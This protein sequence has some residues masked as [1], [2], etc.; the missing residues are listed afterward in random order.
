MSKDVID[1]GF[2]NSI[3]KD[4]WHY[5]IKNSHE[6][7][8][9]RISRRSSQEEERV[10]N[11]L[12]PTVE[13]AESL[14][15]G[16][17]DLMAERLDKLDQEIAALQKLTGNQNM[18][19]ERVAV[20]DEVKEEENGDDC[21]EEKEGEHEETNLCLMA[22]STTSVSSV[23]FVESESTENRYYQLL[24]AFQEL[25]EGAMKLQ[26]LINKFKSENKRLENRI[27]VLDNEN[28]SLKSKLES[29]ENICQNT[30]HV[31]KKCDQER[32]NFPRQLERIKY[33][34]KTL[35]KFTLGSSNHDALLG[36]QRIVMN[37]EGIVYV[38]K[39]NRLRTKRF[40]EINKPSSI[41]CL[42]CK[43]LGHASNSCYYK[44]FGVPKGKFKW[45]PKEPLKSPYKKGTKFKWVPASKSLNCFAGH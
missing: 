2:L 45:I 19:D 22:R 7:I 37:R 32:E 5:V 18:D 28:E 6:L 14:E 12:K 40:I 33:L 15:D 23:S 29:L 41:V 17:I 42:Y 21:S 1:Y 20:D 44:Y 4:I 8:E 34:M 38:G 10:I 39:N 25:Y 30:M 13:T 43:Q 35:S 3:D 31:N 16:E 9:T 36:S 27:K 26:H 11:I 24:D